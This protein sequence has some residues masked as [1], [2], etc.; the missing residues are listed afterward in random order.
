ME[1]MYTISK[2]SLLRNQCVSSIISFSQ[3][4]LNLLQMISSGIAELWEGTRILTKPHWKEWFHQ[5]KLSP[6]FVLWEI[7]IRIFY[8]SGWWLLEFTTASL[9]VFT[10]ISSLCYWLQSVFKFSKEL[11]SLYNYPESFVA[12]PTFKVSKNTLQVFEYAS[13]GWASQVAQLVKNWSANAGDTRDKGLIPESGTFPRE[14]NGNPM[15][16]SCLENPMD[17]EA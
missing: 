8:S 6:R 17:K 4:R 14:G 7:N 10:N 12:W 5:P 3:P 9:H 15:Q 2:L 11:K 13:W 16:Y 1:L